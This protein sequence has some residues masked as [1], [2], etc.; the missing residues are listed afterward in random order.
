MAQQVEQN[1]FIPTY[2]NNAQTWATALVPTLSR[3]LNQNA[4]RVNAVLPK[5][6]SEPMSGPLTTGS[7]TYATLPV[8]P[9]LGAEVIISDSPTKTWG[10]NLSAGGG[11]YNIKARWNGTNWTV[12]GI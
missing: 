6:G 10:A 9:A 4:Q 7:Y 8:A 11:P 2:L 3:V 1:P 12:V 5:D